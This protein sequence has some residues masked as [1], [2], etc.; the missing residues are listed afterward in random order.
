M[1]KKKQL[2]EAGKNSLLRAKLDAYLRLQIVN[3]ALLEGAALF[4]TLAFYLTASYLF[5][6]AYIFILFVFSLSR[7]NL[8]RVSRELYLSKEER[9]LLADRKEIAS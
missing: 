2:E 5:V 1:Y 7:P 8:E 9:E 3:Y 4:A 6:V